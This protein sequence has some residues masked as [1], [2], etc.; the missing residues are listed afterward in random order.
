METSRNLHPAYNNIYGG[1]TWSLNKK[2]ERN[3]PNTRKHHQ[4][5]TNGTSINTNRSTIYRNR[6][7]GHHDHNDQKQAKHGKKRLHKHPEI[8]TKG[9][10]KD[11]TTTMKTTINSEMETITAPDINKK[12]ANK[13]NTMAEGKTKTQFLLSNTAWKPG[14]R[15]KYTNKLT[16]MEA[17]A[18][19]KAR[20]RML[21]VKNN[22]RGKYND[23]K[24]RKCDAGT[25]TREQ[26]LEECL[27][28][29]KDNSTK[30]K[31][32]DIFQD[33]HTALRATIEKITCIRRTYKAK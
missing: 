2:E 10:W 18:I 29:H 9:G 17:S 7:A 32:N 24:C 6:A 22:Y 1:E 23:T 27:S 3:K 8:G 33:E 31:R 25:E 26:I 15:P 11:K 19:F 12:Y 30:V 28:I 16:R 20:T 13:I 4:K 21:D 14:I 5:D